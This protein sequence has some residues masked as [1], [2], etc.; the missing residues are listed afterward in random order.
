MQWYVCVCVC[1][2]AWVRVCVCTCMHVLKPQMIVDKKATG[3]TASKGRASP[4]KQTDLETS[5]S[6]T[7]P[8]FRPMQTPSLSA[9][10]QPAVT[11][12]RMVVETTPQL[13]EFSKNHG[14]DIISSIA[15]DI[16]ILLDDTDE[17][18]NHAARNSSCCCQEGG[19]A[20][21]VLNQVSCCS[22]ATKYMYIYATVH[23]QVHCIGWEDCVCILLFYYLPHGQLHAVFRGLISISGGWVLLCKE[24]IVADDDP[25]MTM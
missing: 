21:R 5:L 11:T 9:G 4:N 3:E 12:D 16:D 15:A 13:N 2:C 8:D 14:S 20:W 17:D 22:S 6:N 23:W 19:C 1:V 18:A 24:L 10:P 7:L 25:H